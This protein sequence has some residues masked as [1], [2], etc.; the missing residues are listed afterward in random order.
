MLPVSHTDKGWGSR[1]FAAAKRAPASQ[2][3]AGGWQTLTHR[4][5]N[6]I[7]WGGVTVAKPED[8]VTLASKAVCI[9]TSVADLTLRVTKTPDPESTSATGATD[10]MKAFSGR[11]CGPADMNLIRVL[12][13]KMS[14]H[15][16]NR[17]KN[18]TPAPVISVKKN[19]DDADAER[20]E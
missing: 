14:R 1:A 2:H 9:T 13:S 15:K 3:S 17:Q 16:N 11:L 4:G 20:M 7:I 8:V 18:K 19:G 12:L 5:D 6:Q 10:H